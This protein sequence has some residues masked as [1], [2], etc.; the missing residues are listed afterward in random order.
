MNILEKIIAYKHK[1]VSLS[2]EK[3]PISI[4]E[5]SSFMQQ[6]I[7][8]MSQ[9]IINPEKSG[10]IAE[11]KRKSPS[12]DIINAEIS[13][14]KISQGYENAGVSGI[15]VLT[16]TN[17]FGGTT[18]DL[19]AVRNKVNIPI[20]RKDFMI[21]EYQ[22]IEAK[23]MGADTVLLIAAGL[24]KEKCFALAEFAQSFGLE[25]LLEVHHEKEYYSHFNK[26]ISIVG[27]NNRNLE[28]FEV[29][30][31]NS[32]RI[33]KILPKEIIKISESGISKPETI[34]D[35]K[36]YGFQGFLL[37]EAFMKHPEPQ[38]ACQEFINEVNKNN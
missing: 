21:D 20:L 14:E 29:S 19:I 33:S 32:K 10:I 13:V 8:S 2:K 4:L 24:S 12:K 17:F 35:L 16:D 31:D 30:T 25:T 11:I 27:V 34:L 22:I 9:Y 7:I 3:K 38:V 18:E 1:E 26:H 23:A 28:T 5:K 37:G 6:P 15:S 36:Q